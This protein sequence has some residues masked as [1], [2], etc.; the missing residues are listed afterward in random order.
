MKSLSAHW[1]MFAQDV[2]F[3]VRTL[4][5][6]H[7][8]A[9]ATILVT[10]LGV[11]ANTATFSVADYVLLR[12]LPYPDGET[13]VRICEGPPGGG[14]WGCNNQMSPANYR[15]LATMNTSLATIGAFRRTAMNLVGGGEPAQA[16]REQR[17]GRRHAPGKADVADHQQGEQRRQEG[18][19]PGPVAFRLR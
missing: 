1:E 17:A 2:R 7:G 4:S 5:R 8:F 19:A 11:G 16:Q 14:G 9:A 3:S 18:G 6:S 13:L 15:D 10:A 12:P